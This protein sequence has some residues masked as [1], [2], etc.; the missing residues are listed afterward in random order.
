VSRHI[1]ITTCTK[2]KSTH[3]IPGEH[4]V[5]PSDYLASPASVE[6][7]GITRSAVFARPNSAYDRNATQHYAFDLYVRDPKTQL[8][9]GLRDTGLAVAA[10]ERLLSAGNEVEWY[11][12]SGG[13]GL[14]HALELARPYQATFDRSIARQNGIPETLR[15]WKPILPL[16]L[17]E[18]FCR[19]VPSS[20]SVF[21]STKYVDMVLTTDLYRCRPDLFDIR[22]GRANTPTLTAA[23][24]DT[25]RRLFKA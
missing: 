14:L 7:L 4:S 2:N 17:D 18:V 1:I 21:G 25:V 19:K 15:E 24:V 10:R 12:L 3:F 9:R 22:I 5:S 16:L 20:V 23:L 13:Y 8:Y 6:R 11:F